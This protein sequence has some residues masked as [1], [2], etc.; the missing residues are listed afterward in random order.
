MKKLILSAM[1][2]GGFLLMGTDANAQNAIKK[3]RVESILA[4]KQQS[5]AKLEFKK[6]APT[7]K[8]DKSTLPQVQERVAKGNPNAGQPKGEKK[9]VKNVNAANAKAKVLERVQAKVA[10]RRATANRTP[11]N[12]NFEA[13]KAEMTQKVK[14]NRPSKSQK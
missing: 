14:S 11:K 9:A 5:K 6:N 1:L 2:C 7:G 13:K 8:I 3:D 12:V 4:N 10:T